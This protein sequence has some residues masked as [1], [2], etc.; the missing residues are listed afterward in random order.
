MNAREFTALVQA[1]RLQELQFELEWE[2]KRTIPNI[3]RQNLLRYKITKLT[4]SII[5][6]QMSGDLKI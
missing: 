2:K 6:V 4:D 5:E 1:C 3:D